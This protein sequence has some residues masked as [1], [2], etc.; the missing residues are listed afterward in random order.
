MPVLCKLQEISFF[1][2]FILS[3]RAGILTAS[4]SPEAKEMLSLTEEVPSEPTT[5]PV[6]PNNVFT[7]SE[8]L[9]PESE[10]G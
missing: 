9:Q 7:R 5:H 8:E 6:S 4:L 1:S 2:S 3:F 10:M